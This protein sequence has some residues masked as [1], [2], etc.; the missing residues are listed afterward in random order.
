MA[1]RPAEELSKRELM[2]VF[3]ALVR[4]RSKPGS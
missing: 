3:R 1:E 4:W 2:L